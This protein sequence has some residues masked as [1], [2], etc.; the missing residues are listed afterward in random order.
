MNIS[1]EIKYLS[2]VVLSNYCEEEDNVLHASKLFEVIP[3]IRW[4][5][6]QFLHGHIDKEEFIKFLS[7]GD[8]VLE[9]RKIIRW[10]SGVP[11]IQDKIVSCE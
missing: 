8:Y 2:K 10:K 11:H 6:D 1:E 9:D 3:Y 5:Y 7:V 4:C